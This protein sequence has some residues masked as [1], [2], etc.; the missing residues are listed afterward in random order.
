MSQQINLF[1]PIFLKQKKYFSAVT[2]VQAL[3]LILLGALAMTAYANYQVSRLSKD[4]VATTAQLASSQA[5]LTR[6]SVEYAQRKKN[7]SLEDEIV[8]VDAEV[9]GL[10]KIFDI[11]QKGDFGNTKGY[12]DYLRA[13][14]RQSVDGL[15]LTGFSIFGAG[16]DIGLQG[17]VLQPELVPAYVSRLKKETVMAGKSFSSLEMHLPKIDPSSKDEAVAEKESAT[18]LEFS[19]QSAGIANKQAGAISK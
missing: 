8:K 6:L 1:N 4:A 15:W 12:S 16:N 9:K 14:S 19:L 18:Y 7:Q 5:L 2:M 17:K 10:Q 3:G 11:M 13:F